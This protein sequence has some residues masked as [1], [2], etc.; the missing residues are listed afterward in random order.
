[1]VRRAAE[2]GYLHGAVADVPNGRETFASDGPFV[3][4]EFA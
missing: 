2:R 3:H 4:V 1:M